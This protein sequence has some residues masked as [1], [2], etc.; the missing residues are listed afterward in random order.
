MYVYNLKLQSYIE[1]NLIVDNT[2]TLYFCYRILLCKA[3]IT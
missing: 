2:E 3:L 1:L